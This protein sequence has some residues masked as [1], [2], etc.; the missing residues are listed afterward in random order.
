MNLFKVINNIDINKTRTAVIKATET[1]INNAPGVVQITG[2]RVDF[3]DKTINL[4]I[5]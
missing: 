5:Y 3:S 4:G 1:V 2:V